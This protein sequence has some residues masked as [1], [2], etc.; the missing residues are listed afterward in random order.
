MK[1]QA[2]NL[3]YKDMAL[4]KKLVSQRPWI[5]SSPYLLFL[6]IFRLVLLSFLFVHKQ[7][8]VKQII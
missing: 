1:T 2:C 6:V 3:Q 7:S 4:V 5:E 8:Y